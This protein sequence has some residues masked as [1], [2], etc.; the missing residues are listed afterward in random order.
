M[1]EQARMTRYAIQKKNLCGL[2]HKIKK[3]LSAFGALT[4]KNSAG[5]CSLTAAKC[6]CC[7]T[8]SCPEQEYPRL[9][10]QGLPDMALP[11]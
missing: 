8:F 4:K 1:P 3:N 5:A 11:L 6:R 7:I 10:E 2:T 9:S